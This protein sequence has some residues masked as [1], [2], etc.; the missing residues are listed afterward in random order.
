MVSNSQEKP[1]KGEEGSRL[2]AST[3]SQPWRTLDFGLLGS[4]VVRE[5]ISVVFNPVYAN[6]LRPP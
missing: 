1:G 4:R 5:Y 2:R 6:L 3:G